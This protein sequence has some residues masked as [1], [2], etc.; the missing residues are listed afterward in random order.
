MAPSILNI[1]PVHQVRAV[2]TLYGNRDSGKTATLRYLY[3]LL[4]GNNNVSTFK[5]TVNG[6]KDF[7]AVV[8]F[9]N[10]YIYL[11]TVGDDIVDVK[12]NWEFFF[13]RFKKKIRPCINYPTDTKEGKIIAVCPSRVNDKSSQRHD[14]Y[15]ATLK[16]ILKEYG[17]FYKSKNLLSSLGT[18]TV[19]DITV[20]GNSKL[21]LQMQQ[22]AI[23]M[24]HV[25]YEQIK[26]TMKRI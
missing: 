4:L 6:Y 11:S 18:P 17:Y 12:D 13:N 8:R 21:S 3:Y 25:L 2:L 20:L 26:A 24:A 5:S 23:Y 1:P 14:S 7:R 16:P 22:D 15:I 9:N 19:N 10:I